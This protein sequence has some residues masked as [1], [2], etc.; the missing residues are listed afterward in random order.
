MTTIEMVM[1]VPTQLEINTAITKLKY[2]KASE[3]VVFGQC[4]YSLVELE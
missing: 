4:Y 2:N 3:V 1:D